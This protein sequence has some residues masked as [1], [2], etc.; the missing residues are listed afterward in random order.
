MDPYGLREII[1]DGRT[2]EY[3]S[4]GWTVTAADDEGIKIVHRTGAYVRIG[5]RVFN[6]LIRPLG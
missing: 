6:I 1:C 2:Y 4:G 3:T 5:Y